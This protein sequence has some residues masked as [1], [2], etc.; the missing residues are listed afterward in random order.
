MLPYQVFA[1]EKDYAKPFCES[2]NGIQEYVLSDKSRIDCLTKDYAV[3]VEF[4]KKWAE[5]I[6]QSV[7]YGLMINRKPAIAIIIDKN[8]KR[9]T[10]RLYKVAKWNKIKIFKIRKQL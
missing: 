5:A 7:Y 4:A 3:E 2:V 9:Y 10:N 6:G 1:L 8:D